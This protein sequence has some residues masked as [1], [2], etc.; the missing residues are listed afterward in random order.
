L[1]PAQEKD[2]ESFA[3]ALRVGAE[4]ASVS[5]GQERHTLSVSIGVAALD[6]TSSELAH[7]LAAAETAC[8]TAKDAG[9]NRVEVYRQ[10]D[11]SISRRL[12]EDGRASQLRGAIEAGRLLLD[13][14]LIL[15]LA[16]GENA[17]PQFE[18]LVRMTDPSGRTVGPD[19][20]FSAAARFQLM[21]L[22]DRWVVSHVIEALKPRAGVLDGQQLGF[23]IN[24]SA[25]TLND[26]GFADMLTE[27]IRASGL[28][29]A[30]FCFEF[31]ENA[32]MAAL[33]KARALMERLRGLGCGVALDDFG[34]GLSSLS[35]LREL[36]VT[37]LKIDG[38]F[39]RDVL[40]DAR[41]ESMVRAMAELARSMKIVSV[42]EYVETDEISERVRALGVDYGQGFAIGRPIA[43]ADLLKEL[44]A[45]SEAEE[46]TMEARLPEAWFAGGAAS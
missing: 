38:S 46:T 11:D 41:A 13:T 25:Q 1:L 40:T 33:P 23:A 19:S 22:I 35:C 5:Q 7:V 30:L 31:T 42:A 9:R 45:P 2:A 4:A 39:V 44:P 10:G 37:M 15:P 21:P 27:R 28:D 16:A 26:E 6:G 14:Q 24:L 18:L 36:P 3:E 43:F 12:A 20:F 8:K 34:T 17:R 32:T 29:A